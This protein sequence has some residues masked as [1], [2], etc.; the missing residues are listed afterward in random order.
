MS[1]LTKESGASGMRPESRSKSGI[2]WVA[3]GVAL[4]VAA[5]SLAATARAPLLALARRPG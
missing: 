3:C 2:V 4:M 1:T 5:F